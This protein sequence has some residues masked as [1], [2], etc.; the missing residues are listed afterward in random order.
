LLIHGGKSFALNLEQAQ[1]MA[2]RRPNTKL[3]FFEKCG[4]GVHS[5]DPDGFYQAVRSF[6]EEIV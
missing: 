4:H 3:E 1:L 2:S 5:D 6:L